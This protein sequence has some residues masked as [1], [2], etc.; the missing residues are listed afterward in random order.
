MK[1]LVNNLISG[2]RLTSLC[3]E[4]FIHFDKI[5]LSYTYVCVCI[6]IYIYI[7]I[8]IFPPFGTFFFTI[9]IASF[10]FSE[11]I[12]INHNKQWKILKEMGIPDK[13]ACL[14]KNLYVGQGAIARIR[15]GTTDW[16][17]IG[18]RV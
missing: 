13:L 11:V 17:K 10:L 8:Y 15:N 6:Y 1:S 3:G 14:M 7:Y 9:L 12:N 4:L 5:F 16:F 18:K 2:V